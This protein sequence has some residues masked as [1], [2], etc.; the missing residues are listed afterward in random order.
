DSAHAWV[1]ASFE[2]RKTDTGRDKWQNLPNFGPMYESGRFSFI[3]PS[4]GWYA[5]CRG[6]TTPVLAKTNDG[7]RNWIAVNAPKESVNTMWAVNFVSEDTGFLLLFNGKVYRTDDAGGHWRKMGNIPIKK[8]QFP[9]DN[10]GRTNATIRFTDNQNGTMIIYLNKPRGY[11]SFIT[12]DGGCTW[13]EEI[14][15]AETKAYAGS[16]YLSRDRKIL[17]ITDLE[18][19]SVI[20]CERER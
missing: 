15:P 19:S 5:V 7:G 8:R 20:M 14:L 12:S 18:N 10:Y 3:T 17:T 13:T 1:R 4:V 2:I 6:G 11:T 16:V 9:G